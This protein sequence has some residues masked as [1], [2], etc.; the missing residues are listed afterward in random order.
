MIVTRFHR[1]GCC[2]LQLE[3]TAKMSFM[4]EVTPISIL[5]TLAIQAQSRTKNW[6]L[7]LPTQKNRH[8]PLTSQPND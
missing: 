4:V 7:D 6:R 2:S 1:Y 5:A 8:F 3:A